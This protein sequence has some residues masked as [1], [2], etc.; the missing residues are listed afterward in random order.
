MH[1]LWYK[2]TTAATVNMIRSYEMA[3]RLK[4]NGAQVE[5]VYKYVYLDRV[6]DKKAKSSKS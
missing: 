3:Q 4:A 2:V 1:E 5:V 6:T